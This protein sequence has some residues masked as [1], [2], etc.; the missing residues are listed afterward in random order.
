MTIHVEIE[1]RF[2]YRLTE[3]GLA[4]GFFLQNDESK[5]KFKAFSATRRK[6]L[7]LEHLNLLFTCFGISQFSGSAVLQKNTLQRP[8]FACLFKSNSTL[9]M[10][11]GELV[12]LLGTWKDFNLVF[13]PF[14][15]VLSQFLIPSWNTLRITVYLQCHGVDQQSCAVSLRTCL[16]REATGSHKLAHNS[17]CCKLQDIFSAILS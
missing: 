17:F 5:R 13:V 11:L 10:F 16:S 7:W 2:V 4:V 12:Q 8:G 14:P 1:K 6:Y 3:L 9:C 15:D